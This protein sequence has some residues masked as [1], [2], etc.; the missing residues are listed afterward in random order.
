MGG[1]G[2]ASEPA[3]DAIP[4]VPP[5][6]VK[7]GPQP[8]KS[9]IESHLRFSESFRVHG[10]ISTSESAAV[11]TPPPRNNSLRY[12]RYERAVGGRRS[13]HSIENREDPTIP[14]YPNLLPA[15]EDAASLVA[16]NG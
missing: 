1:L 14:T 5:K 10:P 13:S 4:P 7:G 11:S 16:E 6:T 15:E 3:R 9:A 8:P 2:V 12:K